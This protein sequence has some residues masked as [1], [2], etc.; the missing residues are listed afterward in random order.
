MNEVTNEERNGEEE[1]KRGDNENGGRNSCIFSKGR[2]VWQ[3]A[4]CELMDDVGL[5]VVNGRVIVFDPREVV[6]DNYH[7]NM[8]E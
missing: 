6:V 2:F 5:F 1:Q 3:G 4:K 8:L 7:T